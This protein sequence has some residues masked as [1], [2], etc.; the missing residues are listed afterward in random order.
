MTLFKRLRD[1]YEKRDR[2][3]LVVNYRKTYLD[4]LLRQ[5]EEEAKQVEEKYQQA[6]A[7]SEQ[8][9]KQVAGEMENKKELSADEQAE[10]TALWKKLVKLYHPDRFA[11]EPDKLATYEKLTAAINDAKDKGDLGKLHE[12]AEDPH[13]FI[14][15]QGWASLDFRDTEELA[16]LRRLWESLENEILGVLEATNQVKA[17]AE[18]ELYLLTKESAKALDEV[19][20]RQIE[21]IQKEMAGLETDAE[22]LVR[23]IQELTGK[24]RLPIELLA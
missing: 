5:G 24:P 8:D 13:G 12:I 2:L 16:Q 7:E 15:R 23:E 18:Y 10:L 22:R 19:A 1:Y 3:R 17:S 21:R 14:L 4:T 6:R 20:A 11:H 9:Y